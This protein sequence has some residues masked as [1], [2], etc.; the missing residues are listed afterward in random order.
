MIA[1][2]IVCALGGSI[3]TGGTIWAIAENSRKKEQTTQ[4]IVEA[5]SNIVSAVS[6][7][8]SEL[9]EAQLEATKNLTDTDLLEIPC[10]QEYI[11]KNSD[12]LCREMFCR[13]QS[14]GL[15]SASSQAECEEISN[16]QNSLKILDA[17]KDLDEGAYRACVGVFNQRK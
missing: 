7:I 17:C 16:I 15:D 8:K 14:R 12:L 5:Q 13:L 6:Q 11:D 9:A 1:W 3:V 4:A 2:Y 10:S